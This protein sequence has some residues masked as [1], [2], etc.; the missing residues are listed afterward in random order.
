MRNF[1]VKITVL[2]MLI[3]LCLWQIITLWFGDMSS[4]NFL[5]KRDSTHGRVLAAPKAI[6]VNIGK[7]AYK[8]DGSRN[9]YSTLINEQKHVIEGAVKNGK[10][11]TDETLTYE[12]LLGMP[13]ILYEYDLEIGIQ[14]L[15]GTGIDKL[16]EDIGVRQVFIDM[17]SY[18]DAKV[19]LYLVGNEISSIYKTT[20][21]KKIDA[22]QKILE[23]FNNPEITGGLMGYQPSITS[24]KKQYIRDNSFL[25]LNTKERPLE[26][27][28]LTIHNP[29]EEKEGED[30]LELLESYV[31]SFFANPLLKQVDM[32]EDGSIIF[33]ENMRAI[34]KYEPAGTLEF[35]ITS[36]NRETKLNAV[37]RLNKVM[38]FIESCSGIP[39]FLKE[40]IYLTQIMQQGEEY[41]YKFSYKYK[42]FGVHLT[43]KV[44]EELGIDQILEI[45]IKN[46]QVVSGKWSVLDIEPAEEPGLL[47]GKLLK[48]Y[49]AV[50]DQVFERYV[51]DKNEIDQLDIVQCRYI[52]DMTKGKSHL[53]WIVL[54]KNNWYYP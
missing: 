6:W 14:E 40:G 42:G 51:Q 7:L 50:I 34:V 43:K 26:Y 4:H 41:T 11:K 32:R 10:I 31:N 48:E 18:N 29:I 25:P 23:K 45:T 49:G 15:V 19:N 53:N 2:A 27:E 9:E 13:G 3:V 5:V 20:L 39:D 36:A 54:Y 28:I 24:D 30:K 16:A 47:K 1:V 37:Q 46:N 21:Y 17:S 38:E 22:H 33:S 44:K 35:N 8:I 12:S 52:I